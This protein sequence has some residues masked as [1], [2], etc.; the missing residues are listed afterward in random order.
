[1][2]THRVGDRC[3]TLSAVSFAVLSSTDAVGGTLA[4]TLTGAPGGSLSSARNG[5]R[6]DGEW[7][8][9]TEAFRS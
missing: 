5:S 1:M 7:S 8:N 3:R 4:D 9:S 2:R 6:T